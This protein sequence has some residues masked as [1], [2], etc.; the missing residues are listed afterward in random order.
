[1]SHLEILPI[2]PTLFDFK[3]IRKNS[4]MSLWKRFLDRYLNADLSKFTH[5]VD[6]LDKEEYVRF[7]G[8]EGSEFEMFFK[9]RLQYSLYFSDELK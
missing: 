2:I 7:V 9:K 1:M 5:G 4:I 8:R 6:P 3:N